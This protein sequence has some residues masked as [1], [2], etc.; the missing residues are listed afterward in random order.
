MKRCEIGQEIA[1]TVNYKPTRIR[2]TLKKIINVALPISISSLISSFGKNIDSITIVR[3]LKR[4]L[5]FIFDKKTGQPFGC[6]ACHIHF[7]F[8]C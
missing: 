1:E 7:L 4:F 3:F 6:P 5:R 8:F 2:K